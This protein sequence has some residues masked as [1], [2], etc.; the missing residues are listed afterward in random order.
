[1]E[2]VFTL[3]LPHDE[4]SVPVVRHLL[5]SALERLGVNA[6]CSSD[7]ELAVTEACTTVLKHANAA[8]EEY[9]VRVEISAAECRIEVA[10]LGAAQVGD[11][12]TRVGTVDEEGG[13]GIPLMR[14]LVDQLHFV[15][16]PERGMSVRLFKRLELDE[17][18]PLV[19]LGGS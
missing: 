12:L 7:V 15:A 19:R 16:R 9:E 8:P 11:S 2:V 10:D 6:A 4:A 1:M 3:C 17:D 14:A 5:S 18:A 13:R